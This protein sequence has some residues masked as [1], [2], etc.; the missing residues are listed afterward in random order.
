MGLRV[1]DDGALIFTRPGGERIP[2]V[3]PPF[4]LTG[5][6]VRVLEHDLRRLG[7]SA[8]THRCHWDGARP[9]YGAA[10]EV[11]DG[12]ARRDRRGRR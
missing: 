3:P 9:D 8:E 5:H 4:E 6:P 11:L 1:A 2:E 12:F 7:V 10:I